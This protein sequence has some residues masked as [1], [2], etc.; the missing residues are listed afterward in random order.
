MTARL[1]DAQGQLRTTRATS[2]VNQRRRPR[3]RATSSR[4]TPPPRSKRWSPRGATPAG[5]A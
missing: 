4:S 2:G 5:R 1:G 3:R